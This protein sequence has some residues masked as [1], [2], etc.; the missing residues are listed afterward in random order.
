M[1][2][3]DLNSASAARLLSTRPYSVCLDV[4]HASGA[5]PTRMRVATYATRA[6][7]E[8]CAARVRAKQPGAIV[9][10]IDVRTYGYPGMIVR[11]HGGAR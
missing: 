9:H 2:E 11:S 10:V 4:E 1:N 3:R 7:A 5:E 8:R 6:A